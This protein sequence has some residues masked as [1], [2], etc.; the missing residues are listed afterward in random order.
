MNRDR[1]NRH[2]DNRLGD[3]QSTFDALSADQMLIVNRYCDQF[4]Q[5]WRST[6]DASLQ[7][8]SKNIV[9]MSGETDAVLHLELTA[10]DVQYR[11]QFG[12][13]VSV[14]D[15]HRLFPSLSN[16]DLLQLAGNT[17]PSTKSGKTI[18]H[19]GQR[20]GD[21]VIE[22]CIGQG[23]MGQVYRARHELMDRDVAIKIL[24]ES[25]RSDE[26]AQRR[27]AREVRSVAKM[28]HPNVV[29]AFD[30]RESD[31]MLCLVTEWIDGKTLSELIR[32]DGPL[33]VSNA[34][35]YAI[36]AASGLQYAHESGLI[37]RDVKPSNLLLDLD[38]NV[39]VLDL[40]LAKLRMGLDD[41]DAGEALTQTNHIVGTAQFL[42]PEQARSPGQVDV[43][44]DVYSLGCSLFFFLTGKPPYAGDT[45]LDTMLS[46]VSLVTPTVNEV[47]DSD[48]IPHRVSE[49][50]ASMMAKEPADRPASMAHVIDELVSIQNG[51]VDVDDLQAVTNAESMVTAKASTTLGAAS[52]QGPPRWRWAAAIIVSL[53]L[54]VGWQWVKSFGP[55]Q[56]PITDGPDTASVI[57]DGL[58]AYADVT[59]FDVPIDGP[60][61]IEV[62][63]TPDGGRLPSNVVSW[64]GEDILVL[65]V[66]SPR[67]WGIALR[68][69]GESQL[70]IAID[71][72]VNNQTY[73]LAAHWD[74]S[75]ARLW[76]DG[77]P[78]KTRLSSYPLVA[79]E[80]AMCFGG[81]ADGLL[82][83]DQG[84]RFFRGKIHKLRL[85]QHPLP[86][87]AKHESELVLHD[88]CVALFDLEEGSGN[89]VTDS[90]TREWIADL[91]D[92]LWDV[93]P[94]T[95]P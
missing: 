69:N 26:V 51:L 21:Y 19:S 46:H 38:G 7:E 74:G 79:S 6:T 29:T 53:L 12:H 41:D 64:L 34:V 80:T 20:I 84:T 3:G 70:H 37:H 91:H 11:R 82:P 92:A 73:L 66:S 28:S 16:L 33:T 40:G 44:S 13:A 72:F 57:F 94:I 39:K 52:S 4:E 63:V 31:G 42:S 2:S 88:S 55:G 86:E 50:V 87:P 9:Q 93:L 54:I 89:Q 5:L 43:R 58:S 61:M 67:R 48:V 23:G 65:F 59:S 8:F 71:P 18:L 56:Q 30:A 47:S 22:A 83:M 25:T 36:Q 75:E 60:A 17:E 78:I 24:L 27:F 1:A 49:F 77:K 81:L 90:S 32:S 10:I 35:E 76:V 15:Y 45:P 68:H 14:D 95:Q 85:S 62:V